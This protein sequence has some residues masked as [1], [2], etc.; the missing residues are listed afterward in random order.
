MK[1]QLSDLQ[2]LTSDPSVDVRVD[3][4]EKI[5]FGFK[6]GDFAA[7][8][9]RIAVEIFRILV[10]DIEKR[11]RIALSAQLADSMDAPHDVILKLANDINEVALPVLRNSFVL[12][13]SDLIDITG[14][15]NNTEIMSAIARRDIVSRELSAALLKKSDITVVENLLRN[16]NSSIDEKGFNNIFDVYT[17][18]P[19]IL[20]LMA[21]RGNIPVTLAEKLFVV[22][23]DEVKKILTKQYNISFQVANDSAQY[24]RELATLGLVDDA[25][26]KMGMEELVG[27]LHKNGR[28]TLSL[29][30]RSLCYGN[31]RFFEHAMAK[32][33]D[34][35]HLNAR[36]IILDRENGFEKLY[37]KTGLPMEMFSAIRYL[38]NIVMEETALGRYQRNDFRQRLASRI[39]KESAAS[40]I[41]YMDYIITLI[42][43]N[44]V[45]NS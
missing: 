20:E 28:L 38:L 27:H 44:M 45:V 34:I 19:S 21:K 8:E 4:T 14:R 13:E 25:M 33:A 18:K 9:R 15:S 36:I 10:G 2:K 43:N 41:E 30:I 5:A 32:L 39:S 35:P 23:S 1:I 40:K 16:K 24:V 26:H 42:Q 29:V 11:V 3:V 17:G 6:S 37:A 31:I 12:T 7:N 22:V